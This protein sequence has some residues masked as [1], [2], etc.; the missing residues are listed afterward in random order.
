MESKLN[1]EEATEKI[2]DLIE[3]N[4]IW[5]VYV[6]DSKISFLT[7][8]GE[9]LTLDFGYKFDCTWASNE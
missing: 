4:K 2:Y 8:D 3:Y 5:E 9:C 6:D 1:T 7:F